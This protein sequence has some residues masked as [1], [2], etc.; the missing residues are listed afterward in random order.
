MLGMSLP[1]VVTTTVVIPVLQA[2]LRRFRV[3]DL[4][5]SVIARQRQTRNSERFTALLWIPRGGMA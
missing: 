4:T 5:Q 3:I 2:S 1:W